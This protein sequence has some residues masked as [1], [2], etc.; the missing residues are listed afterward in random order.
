[1]PKSMTASASNSSK[2]CSRLTNKEKR[3]HVQAYL[4]GKQSRLSYCDT[5]GLTLSSFKNWITKYSKQDVSQFVPVSST[6]CDVKS[7]TSERIEIYKGG[8]K[9]V[10][11]N[12][13]NIQIILGI[14]RGVLL[15]N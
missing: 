14:L 3:T 5:H 7:D 12:S 8:C 6:G 4:T 1:M 15:C 11:I 10:L 2:S 13:S 9:I